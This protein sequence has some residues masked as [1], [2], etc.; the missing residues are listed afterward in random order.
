MKQKGVSNL[1]IFTL[2]S[3][4]EKNPQKCPFLG[5]VFFTQFSYIYQQMANCCFSSH[6]YYDFWLPAAC[7]GGALEANIIFVLHLNPFVSPFH[8][9]NKDV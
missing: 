2:A 3:D 8:N 1:S 6:S 4:W 7:G 5:P 9:D